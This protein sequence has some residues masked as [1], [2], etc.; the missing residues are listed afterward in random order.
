[1]IA[2]S[3]STNIRRDGD[4]LAG[5]DDVGVCERFDKGRQGGGGV[6]RDERDGG[7]GSSLDVCGH[8]E[9]QHGLDG[10]LAGRVVLG[11][12]LGAKQTRFFAGVWIGK[13]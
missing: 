11:D 9:L 8:V 4:I 12:G 1:M 3:I 2:A 6:V 7:V 10:D 13:G 5:T